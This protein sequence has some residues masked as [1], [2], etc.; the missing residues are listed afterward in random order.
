MMFLYKTKVL[1][2]WQVLVSRIRY[3]L[4]ERALVTCFI[5]Y[6]KLASDPETMALRTF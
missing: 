1:L 5:V 2:P 6:A 4:N 3:R